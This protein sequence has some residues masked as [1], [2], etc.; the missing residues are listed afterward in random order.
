MIFLSEGRKE[1]INTENDDKE[2]GWPF[3][4]ESWIIKKE[5]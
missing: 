5:M 4:R 2:I 3:E 1:T